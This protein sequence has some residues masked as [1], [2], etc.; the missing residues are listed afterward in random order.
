MMAL[1]RI[2]MGEF[3][4]LMQMPLGTALTNGMRH[5]L[6]EEHAAVIQGAT[7]WLAQGNGPGAIHVYALS[8]T[9]EEW[10]TNSDLKREIAETVMREA[11]RSR[12]IGDLLRSQGFDS[13]EEMLT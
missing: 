6:P 7:A 2:I 8:A 10:L 13:L 4:A 11:M 3:T 12:D 5:R 1:N 9:P